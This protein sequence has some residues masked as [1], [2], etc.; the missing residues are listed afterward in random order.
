MTE[1]LDF[2]APDWGLVLVWGVVALSSF[3]LVLWMSGLFGR[4]GALGTG[5]L[6]VAA[7]IGLWL[8]AGQLHFLAWALPSIFG[9]LIGVVVCSVGIRRRKVG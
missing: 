2:Y 1:A 4:A 3:L 6:I 5:T 9:A 7:G 8:A